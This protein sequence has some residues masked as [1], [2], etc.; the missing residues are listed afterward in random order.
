MNNQ[1]LIKTHERIGGVRNE[2]PFLKRVL[3]SKHI[4]EIH[5]IEPSVFE[6]STHERIIIRVKVGIL[7][8]NSMPC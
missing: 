2:T 1:I 7:K 4:I 8:P 6:F 5:A 3:I